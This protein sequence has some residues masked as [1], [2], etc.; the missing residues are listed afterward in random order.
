LAGRRYKSAAPFALH[1]RDRA[2][3]VGEDRETDRIEA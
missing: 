3:D 2:S 1:D